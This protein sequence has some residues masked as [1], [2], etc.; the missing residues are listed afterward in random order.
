M[1]ILHTAQCGWFHFNSNCVRV[2]SAL[3]FCVCEPPI[4]F[5]S[6]IVCCHMHSFTL[7]LYLSNCVHCA[8]ETVL[9]VCVWC[10]YTSTLHH[11]STHALYVV[12][13]D[14][15][16]MVPCPFMS[17]VPRI[18]VW[19]RAQQQKKRH[20]KKKSPKEFVCDTKNDKDN[21][22]TKPKKK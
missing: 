5:S 11:T 14:L 13:S 7:S 17:Q 19:R 15:T 6:H 16:A 9:R 12:W 2:M 3:Y 1:I 20:T 21:S 22:Q 10:V 18:R 8:L 4:I